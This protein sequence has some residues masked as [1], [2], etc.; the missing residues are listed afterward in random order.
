MKLL[1]TAQGRKFLY[2][3]EDLHTQYGYIKKSEIDSAK[4]GDKLKTN[5]GEVFTV[6]EANF[7]DMLSKIKRGA[8]IIPSK[9]VGA[10]IAETGI[11]RNSIVVDA[12]AGSGALACCLANIVK[13]VY[14]YE[15]REDYYK[16][17]KKN[18]KFLG[19]KNIV[20]RNADIYSGI[21]EKNVDLITLDLPE[22][23]NAVQHLG[24]ALK[25]G[26]YVVSYSPCIP[27]V[28]DF[29]NAVKKEKGFIILKTIEILL[30]DW[31]IDDRKIRPKTQA[32][33]HSGFMTF[34]R[35]ISI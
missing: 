21:K 4:P 35:K 26:G 8:Q 18:V 15:I 23:W 31:E 3:D 27:Q 19:L 14:T 29:V 34:A 32:I 12:G 6:I 9:D 25:P 5:T 16:L 1:I 13:K 24:K 20:V 17:V 10:I 11:N 33:G 2:K 22:P 28:S 30:R 7:K